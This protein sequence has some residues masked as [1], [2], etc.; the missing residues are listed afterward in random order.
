MIS[1]EIGRN[2]QTILIG[3]PG[4]IAIGAKT[5]LAKSVVFGYP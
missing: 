4:L 2:L 5:A 1:V 3:V